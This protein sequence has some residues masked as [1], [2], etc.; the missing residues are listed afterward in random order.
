VQAVRFPLVVL[1]SELRVRSANTAFYET[2]QVN[3]GETEGRPLSRLGNRQWDIPQLS[4]LLI[5]VLQE[6]TEFT[7]FEIEHDFERIGRRTMLLHARPLDGAQ[8]ILLGMVDITDRKRSENEKDLLAREL[9][10]R[11]KNIL[12]VVQA[13]T[14]QSNGRTR[15]IDEFRQSLVGRLRALSRAHSLLL[16]TRWRSAELETLVQQMVGPYRTARPEAIAIEG[17]PTALTPSQGL[18]LSLVLHELATQR[19]QV[20]RPVPS[21]RTLGRF[22]AGGARQPGPVHPAALAGARRSADR[23]SDREGIRHAADRARVNL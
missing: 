20:W 14:M 16:D 21:R 4:E 1:T 11:V 5:W 6:S 17:E 13:L 3:R 22:V 9:S 15:S 19:R 10:H 23:S 7:D 2:F 8:L 18:G 12:A